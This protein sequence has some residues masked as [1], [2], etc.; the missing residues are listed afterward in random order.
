MF[1]E[2]K[3]NNPDV[4]DGEYKLSAWVRKYKN[5]DFNGNSLL[6]QRDLGWYDW[7]CKEESLPNRFKAL[8]P[9]VVE[10]V[11]ANVVDPD[12]HYV[13][14]KNVCPMVGPTYDS[15]RIC[16]LETGKV[17]LCFSHVLKGSHNSEHTHWELDDFRSAEKK[18]ISGT[19]R[20][21][22]KYLLS[23]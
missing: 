3:N 16:D 12:K 14:F 21:I 5:G 22:K 20:D 6:V 8:A 7:W 19:W 15:F 23:K 2:K 9:K 11:E 10:A 1:R 13:F 17:Q 18:E 4:V